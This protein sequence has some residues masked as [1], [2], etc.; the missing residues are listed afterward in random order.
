[1]LEGRPRCQWRRALRRPTGSPTSDSFS[2]SARRAPRFPSR[3]CVRAARPGRL[4]LA[5]VTTLPA[6][7]GALAAYGHGT[8][9]GNVSFSPLVP[10][11]CPRRHPAPGLLCL[12]PRLAR[13]PAGQQHRGRRA[14]RCLRHPRRLLRRRVAPRSGRPHRD[15]RCA[16]VPG[17]IVRRPEADTGRRLACEDRAAADGR[18]ADRDGDRSAHRRARPTR[19]RS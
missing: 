8:S 2:P 13:R 4:T 7:L 6:A 12:R 19:R 9:T 11:P 3:W 17:P 14:R 1:M 18:A 10:A 5:S 16:R 15:W